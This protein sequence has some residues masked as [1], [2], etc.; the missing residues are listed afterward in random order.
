MDPNSSLLPSLMSNSL[1][2]LS[3][4]TLTSCSVQGFSNNVKTVSDVRSLILGQQVLADQPGLFR[5]PGVPQMLE[6][7]ADALL[8]FPF[9]VLWTLRS[10]LSR[11]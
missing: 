3:V 9:M 4:C 8:Q 10:S 11:S 7:G 1:S 6:V 5:K 2:V